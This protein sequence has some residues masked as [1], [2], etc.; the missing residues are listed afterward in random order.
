VAVQTPTGTFVV[1]F[2]PASVEAEALA[3]VENSYL[4]DAELHPAHNVYTNPVVFP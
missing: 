3:W 2:R 1:T 4:R